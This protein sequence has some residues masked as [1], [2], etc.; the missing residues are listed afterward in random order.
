MLGDPLPP[1][2]RGNRLRLAVR[3]LARF[4]TLFL[5]H[6][7]EGII[8]SIGQ[9]FDFPL[10]LLRDG[11]GALPSPEFALRSPKPCRGRV[12]EELGFDLVAEK[13]LDDVAHSHEP[14]GRRP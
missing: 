8:P 3:F 14:Q 10:L 2:L 12:I 13:C 1:Q 9:R 6:D 11:H 7:D 5:R 4:L